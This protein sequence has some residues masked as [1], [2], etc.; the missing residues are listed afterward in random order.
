MEAEEL[1][2]AEGYDL[3]ADAY[4]ALEGSEPWPRLAWL[5]SLLERVGAGGRVL[6]LGCGSG[7]PVARLL[8]DRGYAVTGVDV[9]REQLSR[10]R[11]NVPEAQL[12]E[13]GALE[14]EL[15]AAS[16]DA[17]VALYVLDHV[18]RER[19]GQLLRTIGSWLR[20]G[21]WLL[22]TFE[23][24]DEPG[25]VGTWLGAPMFF[26]SYLPA[27]T[28]RLV[29]E[30]GFEIV[31]AEKQRQLEGAREVEY[32]WLLARKPAAATASKS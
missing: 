29:S 4:A 12:L 10:A 24:G 32:L 23:T 2:V 21:G 13:A 17:V 31:G 25:T 11:A 27:T 20:D 18:P 22:A 19:L 28:L 3:V 5:D 16:H 30:A 9:S 1:L 26:S 15:P 7:L 6:D 8:V 14:L